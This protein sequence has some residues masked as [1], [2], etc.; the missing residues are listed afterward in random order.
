MV[1]RSDDEEKAEAEP[2]AE[3]SET[4]MA[5]HLDRLEAEAARELTMS[6]HS[7]SFI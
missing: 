7:A 3:V 4:T 2:E 6:R 1:L 5:E